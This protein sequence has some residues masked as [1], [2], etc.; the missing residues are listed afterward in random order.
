MQRRFIEVI[1]AEPCQHAV[2]VFEASFLVPD[3]ARI[4]RGASVD[5]RDRQHAEPTR[6]APRQGFAQ[7][8]LTLL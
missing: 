1:A 5:Q 2:A 8:Q 7:K 6:I 4:E 3:D